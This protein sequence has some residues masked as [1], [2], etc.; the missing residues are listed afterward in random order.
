MFSEKPKIDKKVEKE[1]IKNPDIKFGNLSDKEQAD[2]HSYNANHHREGKFYQDWDNISQEDLDRI[3]GEEEEEEPKVEEEP[4]EKDEELR[5]IKRPSEEIKKYKKK[6]E[7]PEPKERKKRKIGIVNTAAA[8]EAQ[9]IDIAEHRLSEKNNELKG[10][11]GFLPR[12][13]KYNIFREYTRQREIIKAKQEIKDS[14]NVFDG[15]ESANQAVHN[16]AM[17]SIID[18]FTSEYEETLHDKEERVRDNEEINNGVKKLIRDYAAGGMSNDVLETERNR[19]VAQATGMSLEDIQSE[20]SHTDNIMEIARQ[21]KIAVEHGA[22]LD[23]LD[24]DME[25]TLGKARVG[26]RTEANLNRVDKTI[27]WINKTR[28]GSALF[29]ETTVA[30]AVSLAYSLSAMSS[31]V[32]ARNKALAFGTLGASALLGGGIAKVKESKRLKE[33]RS[34]HARDIAKGK[35]ISPDM[36]RR[37]EME[38]SRHETVPC[39]SYT[40]DMRQLLSD[41]ENPNATESEKLIAINL[42]AEIQSRIELSDKKNIDLLSYSDF[43]SVEKERLELDIVRA[44]AKI[45]LRE[46]VKA[47]DINIADFDQHFEGMLG[48]QTSRLE[49]GYDDGGVK[50]EG[51]EDKDRI[52]EKMRKNKSWKAARRGV[53]QGLVVGTAVQETVAAFSGSQQGMFEKLFGHK[54]LGAQTTTALEGLREYIFGNSDLVERTLSSIELSDGSLIKLPRGVGITPSASGS[55]TFTFS[56][57]GEVLSDNIK[58]DEGVLTEQSKAILAEKSVRVSEG[59][60]KIESEEIVKEKVEYT[61][62]EYINGNEDFTEIHRGFWYD[63]DTVKFDKNELKLHWG[64]ING[65]GIDVE[66]NYVYD[67]SKMT[68]DGS[69][70]KGMSIDAKDAIKDGK[71]SMLLSLSRDTQFEVVQIPIDANGHAIINPNSDIA[72]TFFEVKDGQLVF[73]GRFAE[74]G[75]S[76]G[77]QEDGVEK[78]GIMATDEGVGLD[79]I[80]SRKDVIT[81]GTD[82]TPETTFEVE[83]ED[84][85]FVVP[86]IIPILGRRPL[87][88]MKDKE[89]DSKSK[90]IIDDPKPRENESLVP[91]IYTANELENLDRGFYENRFSDTLK[92]NPDAELKEREEIKKYLDRQPIDYINEIDILASE[93]GPIDPKCRLSVCIPV[94]SESEGRNIYKSLE[95][96]KDQSTDPESFEIVLLVNH[97]NKDEMESSTISD[98]IKRFQED[99]PKLRVRVMDEVLPKEGTGNGYARKLLGDVILR[100]QSK[101]KSKKDHYI[102]AN[103]PGVS[104]VSLDY[105]NNFVDKFDNNEE[106]DSLLGRSD[107][108]PKFVTENPL[109]YVGTALFQYNETQLSKKSEKE[110]DSINSNFAIRSSVYAAV[111]G[112][113]SNAEAENIDLGNSIKAARKG[114]LDRKPVAYAGDDSSGVYSQHDKIKDRV[115]KGLESRSD[116]SSAFETFL[117]QVEDIKIFKITDKFDY[118][119]ESEVQKLTKTLE[120]FINTSFEK[121]NLSDETNK[122]M[123]KHSLNLIGLKYKFTDSNKIKIIDP[124]NLIEGLKGYKSR[125]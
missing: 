65:T 52:F 21:S 61:A 54:D 71:L 6:K 125:I 5:I 19:I 18:R 49:K 95:V 31:Q 53:I 45:K 100:R 87:E 67:V 98:E 29:N 91:V 76:L 8:V 34:Q 80:E 123:I 24:D 79:A 118:E 27:N 40:Q 119:N 120:D 28:V 26:V 10:L 116:L 102:L 51:I 69:S 13:F 64:G 62:A 83:D 4:E 39:I 56:R 85:P 3:K 58:F 68:S 1:E 99:N 86:P 66:G 38:E 30:S 73:K 94:D 77:I 15:E 96:Y 50:K 2:I 57:D 48:I 47:G 84:L 101:L 46:M 75:H 14:K 124:T 97:L 42:L 110:V 109:K 117:Q 16:E 104:G 78:F 55:D 81:A 74:V 33:E 89:G 112:Y 11:K 9:A 32:L 7:E 59:S 115:L 92:S 41:V 121:I 72:K 88:Q 17:N 113:T 82:V 37:K 122:K 35:D 44:E 20:V 108:D 22:A 111:G 114:A 12:L 90:E 106:V 43:S 70:L 36:E 23:D 60:V 63:N 105:I 25:V 93:I 103:D 107:W